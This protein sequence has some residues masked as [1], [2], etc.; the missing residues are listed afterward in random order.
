MTQVKEYVD[1]KHLKIAGLCL[2]AMFAVSMFASASAMA[3]WEDCASGSP[4]GTKWSTAACTTASSTGT[5][6]WQEV[7]GTEKVVVK[8]S[9]L[10][11]DA[12]VPIAGDVEVEC[13]GESEGVVGP[14]QLGKITS[15]TV[16]NCRPVTKC[17]ANTV[18]AEAVDLPWQT[19]AY[20]TEGKK[21]TALTE[22]G[23][24][25]P[26]WKVTCKVLSI[27]KSDT[28]TAEATETLEL[29]NELTNSVLLVKDTFL[30][31]TK[32]K[33]TEGGTGAGSVKG[34]IAT[35]LAS[36]GSIRIS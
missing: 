32:A 35:L 30:E 36:G 26:G 34:S 6:A 5:F 21:L 14:G 25:K 29:T 28:C 23:K 22:D 4:A 2:V 7:T 10:L 8:G 13:Y 24:G 11:K 16:I 18:K 31:K 33:C 15:V 12:K 9:L 27:E 19:E 1:M 17:E 20:S 3:H